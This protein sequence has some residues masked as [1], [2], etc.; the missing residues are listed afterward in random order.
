MREKLEESVRIHLRSDVEV[1]AFLS[2]GID[3]SAVVSLMARIL[4]R[5]VKSFTITFE[6]ALTDEVSRNKPLSDFPGFEHENHRVLFKD[7]DFN[8]FPKALWHN[9]VPFSSG[10]EVVQMVLSRYASNHVKTV[11]TGEGADEIF[12][13]YEWYRT[14][15]ILEPL[16]MLPL[17][18]KRLIAG[19]PP[20]KG[21]W[22]GACRTL[23]APYRM[24]LERYRSLIGPPRAPEYLDQIFSDEVKEDFYGD[25][26]VETFFELPSGFKYLDSHLK[27]LCHDLKIRLPDAVLH[28]LDR[29]SMA[30]SLEARVPFLDHELFEFCAKIPTSLK[31]KG[32]E[33]KYILRRSMEGLVPGEILKR[34]K[35]AMRGPLHRWLL[36]ETPEFARVMLS[37]ESLRD[38][39][40]FNPAY[41]GRLLDLYRSGNSWCIKPLLGV[42]GVQ[43]FDE[44]FIRG[45]KGDLTEPDAGL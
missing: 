33:E 4:E 39:G 41:V 32:F 45:I 17:P 15:K 43:L 19:L 7:S 27:L 11:V 20:L 22:P 12:G 26:L 23:L 35:L 10:S 8:L 28:H 16:S 24:N 9:E 21:R 42:L 31:L 2:P 18:L 38:K 30:Y 34:R 6:D 40:Y 1:G 36:K 3:S 5:P 29:S 44:F 14:N 13:G 37:P 25:D